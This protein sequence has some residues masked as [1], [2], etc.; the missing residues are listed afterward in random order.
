MLQYQTNIFLLTSWSLTPYLQ[1]QRLVWY[2]LQEHYCNTRWCCI[3]SVMYCPACLTFPNFDVVTTG[4]FCLSSLVPTQP[5]IRSIQSWTSGRFFGGKNLTVVSTMDDSMMLVKTP[6]GR[7]DDVVVD[8]PPPLGG[9]ERTAADI[10]KV[11]CQ[12][13]KCKTMVFRTSL[14]KFLVLPLEHDRK[15]ACGGTVHQLYATM[16]NSSL[17][18]NED[19]HAQVVMLHVHFHPLPTAHLTCHTQALEP[20]W[21]SP[22]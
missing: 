16:F 11:K 14:T 21:V 18:S 19:W 8:E 5:T 4:A 6:E 12:V 22:S 17:K 13:P 10:L 7:I 20:L 2:E 15:F 1:E 9:P 3:V